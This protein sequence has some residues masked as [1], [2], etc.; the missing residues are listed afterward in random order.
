MHI[1]RKT[2]TPGFDPEKCTGCRIC[3]SVCP[4]GAVYED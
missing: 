2:Y 1:D 3:I 4:V